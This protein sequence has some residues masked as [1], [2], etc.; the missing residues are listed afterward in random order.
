VE[1]DYRSF[2]WP[3]VLFGEVSRNLAPRAAMKAS[4]R[5]PQLLSL[6]VDFRE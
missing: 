6:P 1:D 2:N 5:L 3:K 4:Y